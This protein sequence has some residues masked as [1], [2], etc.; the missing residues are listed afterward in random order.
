MY[1]QCRNGRVQFGVALFVEPSKLE[2]VTLHTVAILVKLIPHWIKKY[3]RTT[4]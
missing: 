3:S 1:T 2:F 4:Q